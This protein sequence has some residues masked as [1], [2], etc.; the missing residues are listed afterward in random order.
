MNNFCSL[1]NIKKIKRQTKE[2]KKIFA[3]YISA[4]GLVS[5]L[6]KD[7]Y[8]SKYVREW[9]KKCTKSLNRQFKKGDIEWS[10]STWKDVN[11]IRDREMTTKTA[12]R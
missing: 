6:Y 10:R 1:K 5:R 7:S 4:K 9:N 12:M 11:T 8:S 3:M 2:W